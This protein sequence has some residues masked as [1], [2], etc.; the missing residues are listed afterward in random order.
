MRRIL[1]MSLA[2]FGLFALIEAGPAVAAPVPPVTGADMVMGK[3]DA[4]ITVI[5]YA[6]LTCPHC[7]DFEQNTWPKV[8]QNWVDTG[9]VRYVFRDFPLDGLAARA[10]ILA[11][12]A[13]PVRF[14]SFIESLYDNQTVWAT[15]SDPM[16]ALKRMGLLGGVSSEKF[17]ACQ[18]DQT[19]QQQIV[20]TRQGGEDAGVN[21]TPSFF[22]N[23]KLVTGAL[24]YDDFAKALGDAAKGS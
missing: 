6:S 19:L 23:G 24:P 7:A 1:L 16:A 21:A 14:F 20:A 8:K 2:L 13:G 3:A 18:N 10:E 17:D 9:K 4:P 15:D 11:H 5:E 22:I 12:C